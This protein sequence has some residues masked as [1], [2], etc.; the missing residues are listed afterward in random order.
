M[1]M[2]NGMI[3]LVLFFTMPAFAQDDFVWPEKPKNIQVLD[4]S[5]PGSRLRA[6]MRGFQSALGV[7][8]S[9]CHI[10]E[11]GKPLST[12]DFASDANPNKERAREMLRMLGSING[13]LDKIKPSGDKRVNMWCHTCHA[14]RPKPM[15]LAEDL[16]EH[17][18]KGGIEASIVRYRE[19]REQFYGKGGYDFGEGGLNSFGYQLLRGNDPEAAIRI[20][21]MNAEN[22]PNSPN[23]WGSLGEGYMKAGKMSMAESSY[24]KVL[25]VD[26]GN[27]NA[28]EMLQKIKKTTKGDAKE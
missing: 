14:G 4:K 17:Y 1:K 2:I 19:L 28:M 13:H 23:V 6:P 3:A 7:T 20:F 25:N 16:G 24:R 9:Y 12:Y 27:K 22:F 18:R 5:W 21:T 15:T 10:G 8:C 26:P 11:E